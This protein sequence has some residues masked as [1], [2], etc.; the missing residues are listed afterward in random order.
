MMRLARLAQSFSFSKNAG[1]KGSDQPLAK[2]RISCSSNGNGNENGNGHSGTAAVGGNCNVNGLAASGGGGGGGAGGGG[3]GVGAGEGTGGGAAGGG[4]CTAGNGCGSGSKGQ[5]KRKSKTRTKCFGG[6]VFRCC[7]PCRGGGSAA[8]ATSPPQTPAQTPDEPKSNKNISDTADPQQ[9]KCPHQSGVEQDEAKRRATKGDQSPNREGGTRAG[10]GGVVEGDRQLISSESVLEAYTSGEKKHSLADTIGGT[11][12]T[13][14]ISLKTLIN[15]VDEDL[16]QQLSAADIAAASLAS[17]LVARRAEPETLSDASVSPTAVVQQL[18]G[19]SSTTTAA[20]AAAAAAGAAAAGSLIQ[21]V[22]SAAVTTAVTAPVNLL[23]STPSSL[24]SSST[25]PNPN[26]NPSQNQNP[27]QSQSQTQS[28]CSCQPQTSP[29]PHIKEEEESEQANSKQLSL[30]SQCTDTLPPITIAGAGYC[31]SC[32][33]VHH[34]SATSSSTG[35]ATAAGAAGSVSAGQATDYGSASTPSPRIKLKFRKPHKSCWSRI[36]LAPIGSTGNSSSATTVIGSNSN[37]TLASS[38]GS[39]GNT[40]TNTQ[41]SSSVSVA[42]HHRLTSSSASA[43]ASSHPSNSQLLPTSKMQAEQGSIGDLQKYHSRYLKNRRHTLANVRFDVENGQGARSPLEGG[44]PSAGL[45]L[46]NLPQRRES[47]LYRSD[48]DFEMSPKSMSRNSSIASESHGEDLIVTPFA[49]ILA[50]LR[51]VR[52]NLLSLTNVPASNKRPAQSSSG[53]GGNASGVQLAQGDEA[54]T[55]LATDTIEELDW[56]LDQL[57]TIQTHRSVSDMASLKFKRMLN[58][59]LSHFSESSRSGNQ[60][61]EYICSTFLDKQ[62]EFDLPS[63]RVDDNPEVASAAA[64]INQQ[65]YGAARARSPRGPP[66]SQIS[67]VKRP[68]SHTNSFTGEKLPTFGVETP[69]ENELGT[70]L[71]ELDTWGIEIFKIG[72]WSCNRPLTCVAYTIFQSRELLTS[73]MIPPKTFLNF[74]TTLEDHYVKDN[75]FHNSLHAADVTQSTNV[76]LNTPALEGVFTPLEV[77]G[78]L[79]AA[80]IHDVDHPGLTNQFLV[81]S[82]SELALMY[83][84]ESVLE[85]HHLAVAFKLL[86][87]QGCDIF[88]NMQKK[89]RQT[90][91]KMVIDI[92]LSTDMSKHMSLL[93][94]LKTMVETKKVA[95]SGVLLLDNYTDRIQV[96]ENLVH[97]ADLSNP[98]KPLPLYKRWVALLMEE[99]FLQGDKERESGMDISPMCDRHNATI[100]KS[101]VGFIDYIVH[102]LWETWADLVH[103]DA[104]DILDTLEENRDYYQSMIPPSPPPSAADDMPQDEKIRFQVTLEESDQENLAELEEECDDDSEGRADADAGS[105]TTIATAALGG[106]SGG[107]GGG[108]G[109]APIAGDAQNQAQQGGI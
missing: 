78:A 3:A 10:T 17:G 92:V 65:Q 25:N 75:P 8:P 70:L 54:Y 55:R 101:Q 24:Y 33:S 41:N 63:L 80:C 34:S 23:T 32:E 28:R 77:G 81:N 14:P 104:Q 7:L 37:E 96:L 84:D 18:G 102:P 69:K 103:P 98:T 29:L 67:G 64:L 88:C 44:S 40:T 38:G 42:A 48:S 106:G 107:G 74:M 39:T 15:D 53:R 1:Q 62:Q 76:L 26:P 45:V 13:T 82:S 93:A 46:Q 52:N 95:G 59:E 50:S 16:E 79:F 83:N 12:V 19:P 72:D 66:M 109:V 89:Q 4:S 27:N 2:H 58:K 100:E 36:V 108:G 85:N 71:G 47:F 49:Q 31:G 21:P 105:S 43:L 87:N 22:T 94:D 60:I 20:A 86:Q 97:C 35:P 57:E 11:S 56:C 6:T 61:S 68:L 51:S 99:F 30:S 91:R 90:L 9:Q 5:G 73:L